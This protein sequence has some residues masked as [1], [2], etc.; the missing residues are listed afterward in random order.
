MIR[1]P[2]RSSLFPYTTLFRSYLESVGLIEPSRTSS[3]Y[4]V[5][6]PEQLQR[7]RTLKE[8]LERFDRSEEH[9]FELQSRQLL[10]CRLLLE[11]INFLLF[12]LPLFSLPSIL[13]ID[14]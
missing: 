5:F 4:R 7:L 2:P 13:C 3:G 11:N 10:V 12:F 9:T 1:R 14:L 6:G 8:L